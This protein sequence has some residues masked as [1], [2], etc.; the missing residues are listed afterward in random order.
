MHYSRQRAKE[1]RQQVGFQGE[2]DA[3]GF[4]RI[5]KKNTS[6]REHAA[7][8]PILKKKPQRPLQCLNRKR[9]QKAVPETAPRHR[10]AGSAGRTFRRSTSPRR[11]SRGSCQA[12]S[13]HNSPN[14]NKI[15]RVQRCAWVNT[16]EKNRA[17]GDSLT[18]WRCKA[19]RPASALLIAPCARPLG[20]LKPGCTG[21]WRAPPKLQTYHGARVR[22]VLAPVLGVAAHVRRL[23]VQAQ[24]RRA[25]RVAAAPGALGKV[26]VA[27]GAGAEPR[28][29]HGGGA[30]AAVRRQA[31]HEGHNQRALNF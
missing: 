10:S 2:G 17:K 8:A 4:A 29:L 1:R 6:G 3:W 21:V 24:K 7:S 18:M 23:L 15:A 20:S 12:W 22:A 11:S 30:A 27:H 25:G 19:T 14:K 5:Y 13:M 31:E 9:L 16:Q 26:A 28:A